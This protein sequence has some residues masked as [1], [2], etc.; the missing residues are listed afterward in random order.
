M[1]IPSLALAFATAVAVP[2]ASLAAQDGADNVAY[3]ELLGSGGPWSV[4]F[5][6]ALGALHVRAGFANWSSDDSF[7]AGTSSYTSVPVTVSFLRGRGR[8]RFESGGGVTVGRESFRSSFG[9]GNESSQF[10]TITGIIGYRYQKPEGGFVFRAVVVPMYGLGNA[11]SAYP[12]KGFFPSA[13]LSFGL[14]F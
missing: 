11:E 6:R 3:L 7:G 4:N 5:E 8:H 2:A 9:S 13:G 12:D 14:A 10:T 1:R